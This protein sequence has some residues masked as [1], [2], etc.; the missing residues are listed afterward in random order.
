MILMHAPWRWEGRSL[1]IKGV[2]PPLVRSSSPTQSMADAPEK[3]KKKGMTGILKRSSGGACA[4]K[5][6]VF[7]TM[8]QLSRVLPSEP[9]A[10]SQWRVQRIE[11]RVAQVGTYLGDGELFFALFL[12]CSVLFFSNLP[13]FGLL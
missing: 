4:H 11:F 7:C 2:I 9:V 5:D 10:C 3:K 12:L 6:S 1:P 13:C 8:R